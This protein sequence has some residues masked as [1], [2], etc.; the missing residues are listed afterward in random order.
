[1]IISLF[2][3]TR[4]SKIKKTTKQIIS[5][6]CIKIPQITKFYNSQSDDG[7]EQEMMLLKQCWKM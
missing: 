2:L 7:A 3:H 4:W 1:M 5:K 6:F